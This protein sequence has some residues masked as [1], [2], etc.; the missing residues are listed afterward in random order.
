MDSAHRMLAGLV[1]RHAIPILIVSLALSAVAGYQASKLRLE[2][3]FIHLLSQS[4]ESVRELNRI[5]DKV[6]GI[7]PLSIVVA[8]DDL[9]K[10]VEFMLV[11]ADSLDNDPDVGAVIRGKNAGFFRHN[12]MLYMDRE[13]LETVYTRL[14][15][16]IQEEKVRQ[17]PLYFALDDEENEFDVSD[18]EQKYSDQN[19]TPGSGENELRRDYY[20]TEGEEGVV[21]R[22]YPKG[23]I[24][25]VEFYQGLIASI[26]RYID[27]IGPR[28]FDPSIHFIYKGSFKNTLFQYGVIVAD[29]QATALYSFVGVFVLVTLYFRHPLIAMLIAVSLLMSLTWTFG[30]T[31]IAIGNLNQITVGLF[32]ILFGL[33]ID[34]GIHIF[35]RYREARRRGSDPFAALDETIASTG[36]AL[37]T[38]TVTTSL[39]FYSLLLTDFRGFSEFG[40]I[41]GTGILF[42][43]T[44]MLVVAPA[45]IAVAERLNLMGLKGGEVPDHLVRRG[46]FPFPRATIVLGVIVT[47]VA[48]SISGD[49]EFEYDFG[50]LR[51]RMPSHDEPALPKSFR[52]AES[53]AIVLTETREEALEVVAAVKRIQAEHGDA[54]TVRAVSSVYSLLP[55]DQEEKLATIARIRDLLDGSD[56]LFDADERARVDSLREFLDV[57]KLELRD[58][59]ANVTKSFTGKNGEL[60]NF[61]TIYSSVPLKDGRNTIAFARE[62]GRIPS[63]TGQVYYASSAHIIF[64]RMLQLMMHDGAIAIGLTL[65]TVFAVLAIDLRN[66][67]HA[68]VVLAPLL[69]ALGWVV[70]SMAV[71][72]IR[73]NLYNIVTFP[74]IIGMGIDNS[75]HIFHRYRETGRRGLRLVLRTTGVALTAT[76]LTTMVGFAGLAPALHPALSS[77]GILSL[78][79]LFCSYL[80][81][82]LLL[83]AGLQL[84]ENWRGPQTKED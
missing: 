48:L 58:L 33:G 69:L 31:Q 72:D 76:S 46:P 30:L 55:A 80:T 81:A 11:L 60:L 65:F 45:F 51:P 25:D 66:P 9:S 8:A 36:R 56:G 62:I 37:T 3:D 10:A 75:V 68:L 22:I 15:D 84:Y 23:V 19:E 12:R 54:S 26:E 78:I 43:L 38:T 41:V 53:P 27:T 82:V 44:A 57:R 16:Y 13:D 40:F 74:T 35:A 18:I 6:G 67:V 32:A 50:N 61:V 24:T 64:A 77:I 21:L 14:D 52:D 49:V 70:G 59:P 28:R 79:G 20:T 71:F 2:T 34:F 47:A 63:S 42:A 5:K 29:L 17:S 7:G 83:P 73:L 1:Y 39:A 4:D